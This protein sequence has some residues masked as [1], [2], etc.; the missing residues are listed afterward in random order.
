MTIHRSTERRRPLLPNDRLVMA[1]RALQATAEA[2]SHPSPLMLTKGD[3]VELT[4]QL[5]AGLR[6]YL[7]ESDWG[8][9][10]A[11]QRR[12][13]NGEAVPESPPPE[14]AAGESGS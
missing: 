2:A 11:V 5:L 13:V 8:E 14:S 6:S 1:R 3:A 12:I 7:G 4:G 10:I 9:A